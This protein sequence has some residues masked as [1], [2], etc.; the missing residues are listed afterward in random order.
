MARFTRDDQELEQERYANALARWREADGAEQ[1]SWQ[2]Q[3]EARR[4][5]LRTR[6][7]GARAALDQLGVAATP[8][9]QGA[10]SRCDRAQLSAISEGAAR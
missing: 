10:W 8:E 1:R 2:V 5:E 7:S 9:A 4:Q 6:Q 3:Q